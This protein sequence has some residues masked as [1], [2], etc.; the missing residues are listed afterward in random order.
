MLTDSF[1][2]CPSFELLDLAAKHTKGVYSYVHNQRPSWA[3]ASSALLGVYHSSELPFVWARAPAAHVA[4]T[5]DERALAARVQSY[6]AAF[7][8][9]G[10]P[11]L[12]GPGGV[13]WPAWSPASR[14]S[15]YWQLSPHVVLDHHSLQC[16]F[17]RGLAD[18]TCDI[19]P[20]KCTGNCVTG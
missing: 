16:D 1:F 6:V 7:A 4:L 11:G 10:A 5:R 8:R 18:Q 12:G 14:A 2:Y 19:L 20:C 13:A 15:L 17:W 9:S 3:G